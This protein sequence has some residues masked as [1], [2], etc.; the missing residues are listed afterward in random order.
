MR[1]GGRALLARYQITLTVSVRKWII[2]NSSWHAREERRA[3]ER[4]NE[5]PIEKES[6]REENRTEPTRTL[7]NRTRKRTQSAEQFCFSFHERRK[8]FIIHSSGMGFDLKSNRIAA[9]RN[10][11][12]TFLVEN[13]LGFNWGLVRFPEVCL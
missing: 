8:H 11:V 9:A 1:E 10:L 4:A 7:I 6:E 13:F 2:D 5:S 3:G 12:G